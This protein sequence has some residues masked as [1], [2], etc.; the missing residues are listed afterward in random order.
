MLTEQK[1]KLFFRLPKET[2]QMQEDGSG[3]APVSS[4]PTKVCTGTAVGGYAQ[5]S[6]S[7]QLPILPFIQS[8]T[9]IKFDI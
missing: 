7:I 2:G 5:T 1:V 9:L 3:I 4:Q 8:T 6:V